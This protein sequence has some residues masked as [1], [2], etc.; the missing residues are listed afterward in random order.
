[1]WD[2]NS[3]KQ[4]V[5]DFCQYGTPWRKI[6]R[7]LSNIDL[8][9]AALLCQG[10]RGMCSRT[11]KPHEQLRGMDGKQFRTHL[12]EP[13]PTKLA[14]RLVACY[15]NYLAAKAVRKMSNLCG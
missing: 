15:V 5:T 9:S 12:A 1:M 14:N 4:F 2:A 3:V 13:Y 11:H 6:T 7:F 10:P 8:S